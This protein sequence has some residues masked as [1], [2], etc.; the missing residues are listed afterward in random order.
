MSCEP[1]NAKKRKLAFSLFKYFPFGGLQRDFIR[2]AKAC[3]CRGYT[4]DAYAG[5]WQGEMPE[6]MNVTILPMTGLTNHH[7]YET[8]AAALARK[9]AEE[10]YAAVVG[11]NKMPGLDVYYTADT[12]YAAKTLARSPLYR[13]T[14]R[15]RSLMRLERA[16]FRQDGHTRILLIT[17]KEK[18][19]YMDYYGTA[20]E[21]FHFLPPG[22]AK[23]RLRPE[24]GDA[25]GQKLRE[26]L[27]IGPEEKV[28]LMLGTGFKRK[29]VDRAIFALAALP[30]ALREKTTLLVVGEDK[31]KPF[32][33][34]AAKAGVASRVR[35]LG[36]RSD[37]PRF[38][39]AADLLLHPAYSENT[40]T[41]LVEALAAHLPVLATAVCGYAFHVE[42]ADAGRVIPS[43]F[44]QEEM[45]R[46]LLET[47]TSKE[48]GSWRENARDYVAAT[49]L[50]SLPERAADVI[51]EVAG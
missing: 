32:V 41:V 35:F 40:G 16:V 2:I 37:A 7:R 3:I 34:L 4:V 27:A 49:D 14:L 39:M 47:L 15:C 28:I 30:E 45:N 46:L 12:A 23:D 26:E 10:N 44:H 31:E 42:R 36:G 8:F 19:F 51:E 6:G 11:F 29:G 20:D 43:P 22:I 5:S 48:A 21:R 13:F 50:F 38:L 33:R 1:T 17:E 18:P 25:I 24:D 9:V